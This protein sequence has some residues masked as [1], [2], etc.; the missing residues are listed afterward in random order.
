[1][2]AKLTISQKILAQINLLLQRNTV[3][4]AGVQPCYL[5]VTKWAH[6]Q[7]TD[8]LNLSESQLTIF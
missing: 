6:I 1:M 7:N 8:C 5:L 3:K 2:L 4:K